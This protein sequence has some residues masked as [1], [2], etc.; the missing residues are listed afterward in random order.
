MDSLARTTRTAALAALACLALVPAAGTA[1]EV[2]ASVAAQGL[3]I[4]GPEEV[5]REHCSTSADGTLWFRLPGGAE[6]ELITSTSDAGIA[7]PGDGSF[8]P[9][10]ETEVRAA[11]EQVR[12]PLAGLR[13]EI[14][15]LP[16]PRRGALDS[17][18]GPGLILLSPGV[19][20]LSAERQHAEF[21]H[22]LGHV[23][24]YQWMPD[25][26]LRWTDYR[27]HRGLED[28][29]RYSAR[30]IHADRPHE[31]FAED[32]RALFGGALAN[33]S[34]SI[35]NPGLP[36]PARVPGL[37]AFLR[38][39]PEGGLRAAGLVTSANPARGPVSFSIAGGST[40]ALD[41]YDVG[42]RRIATLAPQAAGGQ[43]LW[44]W[45]GRD[46]AGRRV[47]RGIVLA[48]VRGGSGQ[49]A[50]LTWLP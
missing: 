36:H 30:A 34:G 27:R 49:A 41:L 26:D 14:Y 22:E 28:G 3:R 50:R 13:A 38:G 24:Q 19:V 44:H 37:D 46:G 6:Y 35:E 23:V 40:D 25:G 10:D 33:Y 8:H 20:P 7:N 2:R 45:D 9:Y 16:F 11:L 42:G 32:F 5:L 29:A 1:S 48:R 47:A 21:I 43:T 15:L 31:I 12:F 4:V 39:L 17:G 18:A